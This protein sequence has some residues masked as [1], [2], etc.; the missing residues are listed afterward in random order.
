MGSLIVRILGSV[1]A[2][3][4]SVTMLGSGVASADALTG[5]SYDDAAGYISGRN[6][7]PVVGTMSG[8]QVQTGDCIV[9]SWHMSNFLNSSGENDRRSDY[10]LNLNCNNPV[11]SPGNPGNSVMSPEGAAAKIEQQTAINISKNPAWC[12]D[13]ESR[14]QRCEAI[15]KRTGLCEI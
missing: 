8:N 10:V 3:I 12:E 5:K 13:S 1:G 15:C 4:L 9:T 7:N 11:A 6:G 2:V 14:M